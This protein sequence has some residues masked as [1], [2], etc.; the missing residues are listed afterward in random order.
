MCSLYSVIH[1]GT[2]V[3]CCCAGWSEELR[4]STRLAV[5]K[6]RTPAAAEN[7]LRDRRWGHPH[8]QTQLPAQVSPPKKTTFHFPFC[9]PVPFVWLW[10]FMQINTVKAAVPPVPI[11]ACTCE[12]FCSA[13]LS[14]T[15]SLASFFFQTRP[16]V[17]ERQRCTF[18]L[19]LPVLWS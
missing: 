8:A 3:F 12:R 6:R 14:A 19:T 5:Q 1:C 2:F 18:I 10:H 17:W 16:R 9:S 11:A 15:G 4:I 13:F 7:G